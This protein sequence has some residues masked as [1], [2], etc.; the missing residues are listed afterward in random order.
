MVVQ[1]LRLC[2]SGVA[3]LGS[4]PGQGTKLPHAAWCGKN[5]KY[6]PEAIL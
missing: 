4:I 5:P 1:Y 2:T 3:G 6:K